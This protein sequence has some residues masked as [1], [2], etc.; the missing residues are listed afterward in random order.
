MTI[1]RPAAV[2]AGDLLVAQFTA[3]DGPSVSAAPSGWSPVTGPLSINGRATVFAYYKV[4]G[5]GEPTS[6]SF[7]L[8][9]PVKW[10]AGM[11]VFSGVDPAAP[12]DTA[13]STASNLG[14][15][16]A[17]LTVP[18]VTT[19]TAGAL[20]VGGVGMNSS[21]ATVTPPTGWTESWEGTTAQVSEAAFQARPTVG[22]TGDAAWRFSTGVI[23]AG[24]LRALRP[25]GGGTPPP[26]PSAPVSS[27]DAS[28]VSG[29]AP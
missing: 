7:S 14:A 21:S 27:F 28:P 26:G 6:Y 25:A 13:A 3:D 15:N 16:S 22:P 20:L 23:S 5:A 19:T 11:T 17:T 4:A 18:G 24:W 12:F 1:P 8:S 10:N 2:A 9:T 29:V